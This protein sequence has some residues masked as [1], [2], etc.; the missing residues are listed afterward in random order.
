VSYVT[1]PRD[2][3][4]DSGGRAEGPQPPWKDRC[5]MLTAII[6]TALIVT[7]LGGALRSGATAPLIAKRPYNNRYNDAPGAREDHLG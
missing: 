4:A 1:L 6:I 3:G 2:D 7:A 5:Q